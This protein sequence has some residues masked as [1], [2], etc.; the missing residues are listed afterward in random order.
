[1][2]DVW[3]STI[4][5]ISKFTEPQYASNGDEFLFV[6]SIPIGNFP[7]LDHE[8]TM[9]HKTL[10]SC[11]M[12]H[13]KT[14]LLVAVVAH[15]TTNEF[16]DETEF[17]IGLDMAAYMYQI[18][19]RPGVPSI[20]E[21]PRIHVVCLHNPLNQGQ[22]VAL[23]RN[24]MAFD[25]TALRLFLALVHAYVLQKWDTK[26]DG[27]AVHSLNRQHFKDI[28]TE[29]RKHWEF[30]ECH[31]LFTTESLSKIVLFEWSDVSHLLCN[32]D[33]PAD[34]WPCWSLQFAHAKVNYHFSLGGL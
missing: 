21:T 24:P 6:G 10:V 26:T 3:R 16:S 27:Y 20:Y 14:E 15:I 18:L 11:G 12:N 25:N 19:G 32:L 33:R 2:N 23:L 17:Q 7:A 29:N 5:N 9:F 1:M 8:V 31:L 22:V 28:V 4:P 34:G 13:L 30:T